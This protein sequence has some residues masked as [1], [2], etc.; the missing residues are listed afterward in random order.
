MIVNN[1][2]FKSKLQKMDEMDPNK[3]EEDPNDTNKIKN[4]GL[5]FVF[6]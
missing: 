3:A 1:Y 6:S 5:I 4:E 2:N